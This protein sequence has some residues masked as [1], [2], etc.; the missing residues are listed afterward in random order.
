MKSLSLKNGTY[1]VGGDTRKRRLPTLGA[2]VNLATVIAE[3]A[4]AP[5]EFGVYSE[6]QKL[7]RVTSHGDGT[8]TVRM[9]GS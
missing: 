3:R 2:A 6:E 7:A 8:V 5:D 4:P 1:W 9:E